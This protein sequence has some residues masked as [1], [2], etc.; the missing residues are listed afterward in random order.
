LINLKKIFRTGQ[1]GTF[2][3]VKIIVLK[4]GTDAKNPRFSGILSREIPPFEL[5]Y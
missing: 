5:T 4:Y 3:H 2:K 1:E